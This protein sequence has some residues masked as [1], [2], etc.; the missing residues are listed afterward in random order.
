VTE[1]TEGIRRRGR[2]QNRWID[3]SEED[4]KIVVT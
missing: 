1:V 4:L 3:N 2:P